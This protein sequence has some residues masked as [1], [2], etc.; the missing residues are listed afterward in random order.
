M[1]DGVSARDKLLPILREAQQY[2]PSRILYSLL[3]HRTI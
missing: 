2:P 3:W 1:G